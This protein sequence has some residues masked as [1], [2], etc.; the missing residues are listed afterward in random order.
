MSFKQCV[1]WISHRVIFHKNHKMALS[2]VRP[3]SD[4]RKLIGDGFASLCSRQAL[5][6]S[7]AQRCVAV[8]AC[9]AKAAGNESWAAN[10]RSVT[11]GYNARNSTEIQMRGLMLPPATR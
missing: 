8:L 6:P 11:E 10:S 7:H 9:K 1:S 4:G 5:P 3:S 2:T